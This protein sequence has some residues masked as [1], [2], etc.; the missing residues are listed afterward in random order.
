MVR[1]FEA[2]YDAELGAR[3]PKFDRDD[4]D[5]R[6]EFSVSATASAAVNGTK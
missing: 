6:D 3:G 5:D 1:Q 4:R 2:L